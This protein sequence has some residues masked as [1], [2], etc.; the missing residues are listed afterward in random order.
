MVATYLRKMRY[1]LLPTIDLPIDPRN[2]SF[3]VLQA[4]PLLEIRTRRACIR[5]WRKRSAAPLQHTVL[6]LSRHGVN[7]IVRSYFNSWDLD[8]IKLSSPNVQGTHPPWMY[9]LTGNFFD[10][11]GEPLN[12]EGMK[13][14]RKSLYEVMER[15]RSWEVKLY[16]WEWLTDSPLAF[17]SR[18][19]LRVEHLLLVHHS[20][21]ELHLY[22][23]SPNSEKKQYPKRRTSGFFDILLFL[24]C[25][26]LR[27][28]LRSFKATRG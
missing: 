5:C 22:V 8:S 16:S 12:E 26:A 4:F 6:A 17:L 21:V 14:F 1:F 2:Q 15:Q 3:H 9:T 23:F 11:A 27:K 19:Y 10:D 13:I 24:I 7:R 25:E 20:L 18:V 28:W